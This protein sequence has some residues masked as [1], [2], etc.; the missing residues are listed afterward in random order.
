MAVEQLTLPSLFNLSANKITNLK[1]YLFNQTT[2][3]F[4]EKIPLPYLMDCSCDVEHELIQRLTNTDTSNKTKII[5]L[6]NLI[7]DLREYLI[8]YMKSDHFVDPTNAESLSVSRFM[9]MA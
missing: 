9:F 3:K 8:N 1:N 2:Y 6:E 4:N 7:K 5:Q